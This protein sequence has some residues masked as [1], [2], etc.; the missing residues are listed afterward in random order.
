ML[1][2]GLTPQS[3]RHDPSYHPPPAF[4]HTILAKH[5]HNL[6]PEKLFTHIRRPRLDGIHEERLVRT[7][8]EWTGACFAISLKGPDGVKGA[9]N[10]MG[11]GQGVIMQELRNLLGEDVVW[12]ELKEV[13][14]KFV[15]INQ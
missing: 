14:Q 2:W 12:D 8:Y 4:L 10:S 3:A 11:D 9:E 1:Q 5:R 6:Q 7:Y 15:A 13:A